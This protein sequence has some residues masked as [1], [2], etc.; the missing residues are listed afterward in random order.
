MQKF[1]RDYG[2]KVYEEYKDLY[3]RT[4]INNDIQTTLRD[5]HGRN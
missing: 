2:F 1:L 4:N 5:Y 3:T